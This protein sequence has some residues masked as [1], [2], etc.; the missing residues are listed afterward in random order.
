MQTGLECS[1]ALTSFRFVAVEPSKESR[2]VARLRKKMFPRK[3]FQ[4][5]RSKAFRIHRALIDG[6][7]PYYSTSLTVPLTRQSLQEEEEDEDEFST[8]SRVFL[9]SLCDS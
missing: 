5:K 4:L 3:S 6:Q 9:Y 1:W 2:E 8:E 7:G